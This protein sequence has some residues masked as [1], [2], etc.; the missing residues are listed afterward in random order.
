MREF[1]I[2]LIYVEMLGHDASFG[3]IHAIKLVTSKSLLEKR[4]GYLASTLFIH[5]EDQLVLLLISSI[6]R[7]LASDNILEIS[8]ALTAVVKL[9]NRDTMPALL[10]SVIKCLDHKDGY[11]R[12]KAV[13]AL[14]RFYQLDSTSLASHDAALRKTLCDSNISVMAASLI[15]FHDLI[16][17]CMPCY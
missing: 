5:P 16:G 15:L 2:R 14:H 11:V 12:K 9:A 6:T 10:P 7:D 1:L 8:M 4:V 3:Y 17:R 13:L